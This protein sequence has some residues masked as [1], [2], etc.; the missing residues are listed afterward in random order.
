MVSYTQ[1]TDR[2]RAIRHKRAGKRTATLREKFGSTPRF[3]IHPEGYDPNAA[4][5]K[6]A[7]PLAT[8][9]K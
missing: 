9:S 7:T 4:D 3:P 5:A 6:P 8:E 2:R 1:Q